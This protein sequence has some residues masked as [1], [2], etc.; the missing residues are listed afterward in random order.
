MGIWSRWRG[1]LLAQGAGV[2][3]CSRREKRK[4]GSQFCDKT[5]FCGVRTYL[6]VRTSTKSMGPNIEESGKDLG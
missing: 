2:L 6:S 4:E 1:F 5:D 3:F